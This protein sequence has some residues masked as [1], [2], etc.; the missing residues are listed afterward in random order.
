MLMALQTPK[1]ARLGRPL[2]KV[3]CANFKANHQIGQSD[4]KHRHKYIVQKFLTHFVLKLWMN[5]IVN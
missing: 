2:A 5:I 1:V 3:G 4:V